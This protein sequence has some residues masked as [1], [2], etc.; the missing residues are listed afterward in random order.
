MKKIFLLLI[1]L[2]TAIRCAA[3]GS[4]F[5]VQPLTGERVQVV[6]GTI[7]TGSANVTIPNTTLALTD[8][9]TN[10]IYITNSGALVIGTSGFAGNF[11]VA[12][13]IT[14]NTNIVS[15]TD[16]RAAAAVPGVALPA[17][18]TVSGPNITFP[19]NVTV[20]G[21]LAPNGTV[22]MS[23]GQVLSWNGDTGVSRGSANAVYVG[24]GT[25]GNFSGTLVG[26]L[27]Q[28]ST[29]QTPGG[30]FAVNNNKISAYNGVTTSN[31]GVPIVVPGPAK[32]TA[33]S[34]AIS[35]ALAFATG[36][37]PGA[38]L[39]RLTYVATVTTAATT[40]ST[41]GGTNGFQ[42]TFTNANG[43]SVIKTS[44]PTTPNVSGGNTTNTTVSGIVVGYAAA[45]SNIN[46]SFGYTSSGATAMQ[47]DIAIFV[48]FMGL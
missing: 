23:S 8:N 13:V 1:F 31:G 26:G 4:A 34:A 2:L 17:G 41:L 12:T 3:Q 11:P 40:S 7:F 6:G 47:F 30:A 39:Y 21:T 48:E 16:N 46:Y 5:S 10:Y 15:I 9:A 14:A 42:V 20:T 44:N 35:N 45:S 28:A 33:Q 43:D 27:F 22:A 19:G 18:T 38:G 29:Y 36:T 32:L 25:P 37:A 24:N